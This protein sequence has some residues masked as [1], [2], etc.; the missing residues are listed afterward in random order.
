MILD[1]FENEA[2]GIA[3]APEDLAVVESCARGCGR[4]CDRERPA[5]EPMGAALE[6]LS[7][8]LL[9]LV[10]PWAWLCSGKRCF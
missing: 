1:R 10:W 4:A 9:A 8:Q 5:V 2:L 3:V 7:A 6:A